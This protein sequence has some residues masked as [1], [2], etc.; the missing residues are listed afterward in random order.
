MHITLGGEDYRTLSRCLLGLHTYFFT[1]HYRYPDG[2][3]EERLLCMTLVLRSI[4]DKIFAY[5]PVQESV[6]HTVRAALQQYFL[7]KK[8]AHPPTEEACGWFREVLGVSRLVKEFVEN[9]AVED[10]SAYLD[11]TLRR[12]GLEALRAEIPT[13]GKPLRRATLEEIARRQVLLSRAECE[14]C[15]KHYGPL[16]DTSAKQFKN[17]LVRGK[18]L[19]LLDDVLLADALTDPSLYSALDSNGKRACADMIEAVFPLMSEAQKQKI[20]QLTNGVMSDYSARLLALRH[21][22][23]EGQY[24]LRD[25]FFVGDKAQFKQ[26][27]QD[28]ASALVRKKGVCFYIH[29]DLS[30]LSLDELDGFGGVINGLVELLHRDFLQHLDRSDYALWENDTFK[31]IWLLSVIW[32]RKLFDELKTQNA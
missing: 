4:C 15:W 9:G 6:A 7:L 26:G 5:Q 17:A 3:E 20:E 29:Y 18:Y 32:F 23:H 1:L 2:I 14:A 22:T 27:L 24:S 21:R 31:I 10:I 13:E 30:A 12:N 8:D 11:K 19:V 28:F 16:S 25:L